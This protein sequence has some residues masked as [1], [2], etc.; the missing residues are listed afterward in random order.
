MDSPSFIYSSEQIT[1]I[2][3][4]EDGE[5]AFLN[6]PTSDLIKRKWET[7]K[8]QLINTE[9][10]L[11]TLREYYK[12]E[13][14]PRGLRTHL[15]P[16][17]FPN[18]PDFHTKF[19][20]IANRFS[21]DIM[22]L[23]MEFLQKEVQNIQK[24]ILAYEIQLKNLMGGQDYVKMMEHTVEDLGKYKS[25]IETTKRQKWFRDQDDYIKGDIYKMVPVPR[26]NTT[27]R[28]GRVQ[29]PRKQRLNFTDTESSGDQSEERGFLGEG[30]A[31]GGG[32]ASTDVGRTR[33]ENSRITR[34]RKPPAGGRVH[35]TQPMTPG[36][37]T[38]S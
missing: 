29:R 18:N 10:H 21:M 9:L 12:N 34:S 1:H 25:N 33:N 6:T 27:Y 11:S 38:N 28:Q 30:G 8:K 22:L 36:A 13:R 23:N 26:K 32:D 4:G 16:I 5:G 2:L 35:T 17:L 7:E 20:T 24:K 37:R 3:S 14:I 19:A 31:P 15:R